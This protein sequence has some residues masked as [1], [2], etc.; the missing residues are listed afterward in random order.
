MTW[1]YSN[2]LTTTKDKVR[3]RVGDTNIDKPLLDDEEIAS[4]L[5]LFGDDVRLATVACIKAIIAKLARD[6][7]RSNLGMSAQRSQQIQHYRDLLTEYQGTGIDSAAGVAEMFVGGLSKATEDSFDD[8]PDAKTT[9]FRRGMDDI[10]TQ[11]D[12]GRYDES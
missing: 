3:F 6:Y 12:R 2:A 1:T 4:M 5:S 11:R 7:D 8:D 10:D 9:E